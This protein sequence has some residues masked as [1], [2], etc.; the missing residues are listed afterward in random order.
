MNCK[1]LEVVCQIHVCSK[2]SSLK[3]KDHRSMMKNPRIEPEHV[4]STC[5]PL[6]SEG[7]CF[8]K[9]SKNNQE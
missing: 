5:R 4:E 9:D 6:N 7:Q 2:F 3:S 8:L 1:K